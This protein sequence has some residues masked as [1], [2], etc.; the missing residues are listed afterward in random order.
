MSE[1]KKFKVGKPDT[2]E[3]RF[4]ATCLPFEI[5]GHTSHVDSALSIVRTSKIRPGLVFDESKLNT[6]RILVAWMSPNTWAHGYRYGG[7]KFD[8]RFR[9]MVADKNYYWVEA[10]QYPRHW[11]LRI[12]VTDQDR[13]KELTEYE[14]T[15]GDGPWWYDEKSGTDYFNGNHC[16][17]FMFE[18]EIS[19]SDCAGIGFEQ[20]HNEYCAA[21]R[22]NP[23]NCKE[24]GWQSWKSGA[25]FLTKAIASNTSLRQISGHLADGDGRRDLNNALEFIIGAK[26]NRVEFS[27][28]IDKDADLAPAVARAVLNADAAG[29]RVEARRLAGLFDSEE[30][31]AHAVA[32]LVS[33]AL[34]IEDV[35]ALYKRIMAE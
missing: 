24:L 13:S 27:G 10:I 12:L 2:R 16:L 32:G 29:F 34:D 26:A 1:W 7:I 17:E 25:S 6:S 20:H 5:V 8:F 21:N 15:A 18:Q 4:E 22:R 11:A 3:G 23:Q 30:S 33:E 14:P 31:L 28:D 35:D 19:L 9:D